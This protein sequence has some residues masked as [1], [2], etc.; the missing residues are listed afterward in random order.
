MAGRPKRRARGNLPAVGKPPIPGKEPF[1]PGNTLSLIH[2]MYSKRIRGPMEETAALAI[3]G[4]MQSG[5]GHVYNEVLDEHAIRRA[6]RYL[7]TV[8]MVEAL[9]DERGIENLSD[10]V[11]MDYDKAQTR[12]EKAF[13][14]LGMTPAARGRLGVDVA[15]A[16]DLIAALADRRVLRDRERP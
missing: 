5:L 13:E 3:R 8:E 14:T 1:P 11:L 12:L 4:A 15:R 10:R 9:I 6:A 2:G 16:S 7:A